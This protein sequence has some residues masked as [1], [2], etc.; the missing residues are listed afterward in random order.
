VTTNGE[1]GADLVVGADGYAST[2]RRFVVPE[3]PDAVYGGYLLWRGL[4]DEQQ[5][6]GRFRRQRHP[7]HRTR[8]RSGAAGHVRGA[9]T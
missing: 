7:I 3:R 1:I 8:D 9:R 6:Q 2:V 5:V 4:V